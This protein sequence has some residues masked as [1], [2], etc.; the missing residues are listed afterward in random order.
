MQCLQQLVFTGN[1]DP[2]KVPVT[3]V[4]AVKVY[5]LFSQASVTNMTNVVLVS[6]EKRKQSLL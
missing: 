4:T 6:N 2:R 5:P 3:L 1:K